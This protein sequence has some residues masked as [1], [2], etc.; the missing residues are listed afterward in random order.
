MILKATDLLKSKDAVPPPTRPEALRS[1]AG[2][3]VRP[4]R[5]N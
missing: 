5:E 2:M 4:R 1:V 3:E